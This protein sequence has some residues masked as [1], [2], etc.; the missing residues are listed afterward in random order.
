MSKVFKEAY[1]GIDTSNYRTSAALYYTDGTYQMTPTDPDGIFK[2]N[3]GDVVAP[4]EGINSSLGA[5]SP[6]GNI[7]NISFRDLTQYNSSTT[8]ASTYAFG[9]LK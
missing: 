8:A 6:D 5:A 4:I 7:I 1:L 2:L 9:V 3:F